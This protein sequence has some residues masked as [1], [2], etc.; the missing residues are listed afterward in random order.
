M[1]IGLIPPISPGFFAYFFGHGAAPGCSF[2]AVPWQNGAMTRRAAPLLCHAAPLIVAAVF[3]LSAC[4]DGDKKQAK[5]AAKALSDYYYTTW[6]APSPD[7]EV[8]KVKITKDNRVT[9]DANITT[10]ALTMAVMER[11]KAEQME[12]A[13]MACPVAKAEIWSQVAKDQDVGVSL[14]GKAGHII[15]ALCKHR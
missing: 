13:R 15:N 14:S 8:R 1:Q 6:Q 5:T 10:K 11:S 7:W 2:G 4:G 9:V 3:V 12:I